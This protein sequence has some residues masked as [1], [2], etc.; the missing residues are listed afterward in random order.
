MPILKSDRIHGC[1][2]FTSKGIID[3]TKYSKVTVHLNFTA[4]VPE[5]ESYAM[6]LAGLLVVGRVARRRLGGVAR[7]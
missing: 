1:G 3:K 5:P 7:P 2:S 6:L 4:A